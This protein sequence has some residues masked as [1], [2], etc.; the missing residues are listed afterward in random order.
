MEARTFHGFFCSAF[1]VQSKQNRDSQIVLAVLH[2]QAALF[3]R[4][5]AFLVRVRGLEEIDAVTLRIDTVF[6]DLL[7]LGFTHQTVSDLSDLC[8]NSPQETLSPIA[9]H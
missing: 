5:R 8:P 1:F 9:G 7:T 4:A 2:P 3:D 6:V